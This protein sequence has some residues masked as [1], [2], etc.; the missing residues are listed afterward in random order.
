M[1]KVYILHFPKTFR[2]FHLFTTLESILSYLLHGFSAA[3]FLKFGTVPESI[4][5]NSLYILSYL[6]RSCLLIV[7]KALSPIAVTLNVYPFILMLSA[8]TRLFLLPFTPAA[9]TVPFF[10]SD[11]VTVYF[12]PLYTTFLFSWALLF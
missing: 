12:I 7:L 1:L 9:L 2:Q 6:Y 11:L 8:I 3:Y 4:L 5:S 10:A